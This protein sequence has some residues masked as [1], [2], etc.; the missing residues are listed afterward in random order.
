MKS[1]SFWT[2][3]RFRGKDGLTARRKNPDAAG[4]MHKTLLNKF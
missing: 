2:F 3:G 4:L 1:T